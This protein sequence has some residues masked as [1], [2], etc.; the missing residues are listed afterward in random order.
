M[1]SGLNI[2]VQEAFLTDAL[3]IPEDAAAVSA[4]VVMSGYTEAD[5]SGVAVRTV[6]DSTPQELVFILI[7]QAEF[8][9]IASVH[10]AGAA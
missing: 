7:R 4:T 1:F 10:R 2:R 3:D 5:R 6:A 9:R 8:W